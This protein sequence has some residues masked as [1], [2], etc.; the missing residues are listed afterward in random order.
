MELESSIIGLD[1]QPIKT[2][3]TGLELTPDF[4]RRLAC[5][6]IRAFRR[7]YRYVTKGVTMPIRDT[8][9]VGR[10]EPCPCGSLK[11]F[12]HCHWKI[13]EQKKT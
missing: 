3:Y 9:Y 11:L 6:R 5:T 12:K 1:G 8:V 10:N 13:V 7:I 4:F 2:E